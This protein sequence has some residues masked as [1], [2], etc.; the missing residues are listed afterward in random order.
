M[1]DGTSSLTSTELVSRLCSPDSVCSCLTRLA[2]KVVGLV[3]V[4]KQ[5]RAPALRSLQQQH[6]RA[7]EQQ[8]CADG[9][10]DGTSLH[11][12]FTGFSHKLQS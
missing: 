6:S 4:L 9:R 7:D 8:R 12:P 10:A 11:F 2:I 1:R 3:V 5:H